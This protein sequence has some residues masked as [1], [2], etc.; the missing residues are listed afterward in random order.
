MHN[1]RA[2]RKQRQV[3]NKCN[4]RKCKATAVR[5]RP[6]CSWRGHLVLIFDA[7]LR[8][9][10]HDDWRQMLLQAGRLPPVRVALQTAHVVPRYVPEPVENHTGCLS[11]STG[12]FR[13]MTACA[14]MQ[15]I[16][17]LWPTGKASFICEGLLE[18]CPSLHRRAPIE[19]ARG[20]RVQEKYGGGDL[21]RT[22]RG[23]LTPCRRGWG[24]RARRPRPEA[25][26]Q[27]PAVSAAPPPSSRTPDT[28]R[29]STLST[30]PQQITAL[31]SVSVERLKGLRHPYPGA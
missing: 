15:V 12:P 11:I 24:W 7:L 23:L 3:V 8:V 20:A 30:C 28:P 6:G 2:Y 13:S 18:C 26:H 5:W 17:Q 14:C 31:F 1:A 19:S 10:L 27:E 9:H 22:C 16:S 25:Q 29:S 21:G 4:P